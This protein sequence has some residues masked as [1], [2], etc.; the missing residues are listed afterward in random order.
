MSLQDLCPTLT[1]RD[2]DVDV[3]YKPERWYRDNCTRWSGS[4]GAVITD[5]G[6]T[7]T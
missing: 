3:L 1:E 5:I 6:F 2:K 4:D 7:P